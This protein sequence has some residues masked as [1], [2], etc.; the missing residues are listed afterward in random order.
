MKLNKIRFLKIAGGN[1]EIGKAIGRKQKK[2]INYLFS[3]LILKTK[4]LQ[5]AQKSLPRHEKFFPDFIA[6]LKG[7]ADGANASFIDLFAYNCF[8]DECGFKNFEGKC[9]T[10]FW[11][12]NQNAFIGHNEEE[13]AANYGKLLFVKANL[14][15]KISFITLNYPGLLCGDSISINSFRMIHVLDTVY[16]KKRYKAGFARSFIGRALLESRSVS[17]SRKIL[18]AFPNFT[19]LHFMIFSQKEN[20]GIAIETYHK[21]LCETLL[22]GNYAHAV[23]Y[24]LNP[25]KKILQDFN[26]ISIFK[27]K[28]A[29]ALMKE[30]QKPSFEN[31]KNIL[32]DH[33]KRPTSICRHPK[34][35]ELESTVTLASVII[36]LKKLSFNVANGNP[37]MNKYFKFPPPTETPQ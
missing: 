27:V 20:R 26:P 19:G 10:I 1:Y 12:N 34:R 7:I 3:K 17:Q 32:S 37:C 5:A 28:R 11:E 18:S 36:D 15:K 31:V 24:I 35:G 14:N 30:L 6:E 9:T 23:H 22:K 4:L 25:F 16:P 33:Y 2:E 13:F 29:N 8:E 21:K